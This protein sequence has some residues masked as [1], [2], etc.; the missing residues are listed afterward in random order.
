MLPTSDGNVQWSAFPPDPSE[1][2]SKFDVPPVTLTTSTGAPLKACCWDASQLGLRTVLS[3][4]VKNYR[5]VGVAQS[6]TQTRLS[7]IDSTSCFIGKGDNIIKDL[8][9]LSFL[10]LPV[11][12]QQKVQKLESVHHQTD[13]R[14]F[15]SIFR[16]LSGSSM[17]WGTVHVTSTPLRTLDFV[18]GST[19]C[20]L[21]LIHI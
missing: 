21:S 12:I 3:K 10:L 1:C 13:N 14:F 7:T 5:V 15:P 11:P 2:F 20:H 4:I 16:L 9:H 17:S 18:Y 19:M 8:S 6:V